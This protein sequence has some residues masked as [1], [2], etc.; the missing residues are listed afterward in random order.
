MTSQM[1]D[2]HTHTHTHTQGLGVP[3][4]IASYSLLTY[5]IAHICNLKVTHTY[6]ASSDTHTVY[7]S[8]LT[9]FPLPGYLLF[10]V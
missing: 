5:M 6:N 7:Y 4:N 2:T 8:N 1:S 3:F 10:A 9:L